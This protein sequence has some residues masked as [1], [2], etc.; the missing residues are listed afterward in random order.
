M[1][2]TI[3]DAFEALAHPGRGGVPTSLFSPARQWKATALHTRTVQSERIAIEEHH[4]HSPKQENAGFIVRDQQANQVEEVTELA[5]R[6]LLPELV[7]GDQHG[8]GD[9]W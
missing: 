5:R 3:D 8:R 9:E 6:R 2:R 7:D 1:D 4:V